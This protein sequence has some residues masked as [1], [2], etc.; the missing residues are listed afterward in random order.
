MLEVQFRP[1]SAGLLVDND[2]D[3]MAGGGTAE[4]TV[5][6]AAAALEGVRFAEGCIVT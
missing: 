2:A 6:N 1:T 4:A 3:E 5:V